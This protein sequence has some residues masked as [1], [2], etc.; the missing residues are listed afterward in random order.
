MKNLLVFIFS[1]P[2]LLCSGQ[3]ADNNFSR[4]S[5]G[6]N[7]SVNSS[8]FAYKALEEENKLLIDWLKDISSPKKAFNAGLAIQYRLTNRLELESGVQYT[9]QASE[10]NVYSFESNV[11]DL[12]IDRSQSKIRL[13]Y[14]EIP[15][16][17]NYRLIDRDL[18]FYLTGGIAA[19]VF[20]KDQ[21]KNILHYKN[22][23]TFEA[24]NDLGNQDL[25]KVIT[26]LMAGFGLGYNVLPGFSIRLEPLFRYGIQSIAKPVSLTMQNYSYGLQGGV[27]FN[28]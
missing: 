11:I 8:N 12:G 10:R 15:L 28:L 1:F 19:N 16:R 5:I 24:G 14:L 4:F 3:N 9:R 6:V 25:N 27:Y 22:G 17:L 21:T 20:L 26:S 2:Y 23:N 18:F 13:D 7:A